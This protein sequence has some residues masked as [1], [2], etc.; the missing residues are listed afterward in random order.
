M[1]ERWFQPRGATQA[2]ELSCWAPQ[3]LLRPYA[4]SA[5]RHQKQGFSLRAMA[6]LLGIKDV[7]IISPDIE[8]QVMEVTMVKGDKNMW[9]DSIAKP[10]SIKLENDE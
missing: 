4:H 5:N 3:M 9:L 6:V 8:D 2:V 7:P 1:A 10:I